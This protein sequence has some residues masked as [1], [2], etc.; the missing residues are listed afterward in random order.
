MGLTSYSRSYY[1]RSIMSKADFKAIKRVVNSTVYNTKGRG[2]LHRSAGG[3]GRVINEP[4]LCQIDSTQSIYN[5]YDVLI[6]ED[7]SYSDTYS[8]GTLQFPILSFLPNLPSGSFVW[9]FPTYTQTTIIE[10]E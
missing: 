4:K 9:G 6:F 5:V 1:L 3:S 8:R 2:D 7:G 10:E